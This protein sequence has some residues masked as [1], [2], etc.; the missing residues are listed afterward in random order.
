MTD[1]NTERQPTVPEIFDRLVG[2]G[3]VPALRRTSGTYEINIDGGGKWFLK[4]DHGTPSIQSRA[5]HA[6]CTV[7]LS[8][9]EFIQIAQG[10]QNMVTAFLRGSLTC[11]GDLAFALNFRRLVPVS[12]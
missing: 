5:E 1:T 7:G 9:A 6:D 4:L 11:S 10:K 2:E 3:H 8:A 12:A